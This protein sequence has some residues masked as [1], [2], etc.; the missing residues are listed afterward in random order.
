MRLISTLLGLLFV[1]ALGLAA[2]VLLLPDPTPRVTATVVPSEAERRWGTELLT[3]GLVRGLDAGDSRTIALSEREFAVLTHLV[4]VR[5]IEGLGSKS[6]NEE[7]L[8]S[9]GLGEGY[10]D[11]EASLPLPWERG[12]YLNLDLRLVQAQGPPRIARLQVGGLPL[13]PAVAGRLAERG[14]GALAEADLVQGVELSADQARITYGW[15]PD[16]L[17]AAG[18]GM[19]D[20]ADRHRLLAAQIRLA[21]I[22]AEV[23]GRGAIPLA[24]LL[25][26]LLATAPTGPEQDPAADNRAAI[27]ALAIYVAGEAPPSSSD[28]SRPIP[29][30][31][32]QLR[33][34]ADLA[35]HY[36]ASAV[37]ATE[38]GSALSDLIGFA[39]E[40]RDSDG[41]SGFSFADLAADRAGIRFAELATGAAEDALFV[42]GM[43]RAGLDEGALMPA[44]EGLPEGL[45]QREFQRDFGSHNSDAYRQ[46]V[47]HIDGRIDRLALFTG[48]SPMSSAS[49]R[50]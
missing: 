48:A 5:L 28:G 45:S 43:A 40:L 20:R 26:R 31:S 15:R 44:I 38:G 50:G 46:I 7:V 30:R 3:G 29:V 23:P 21:D 6:P 47:A 34:R 14:L 41:G 24:Q 8:T 2:V 32:V 37:I 39:K 33:G 18:R 4:A 19:L 1:L 35:K 22:L 49:G 17:A 27:L 9:V 42:Q 11:I 10:V 12:G 13:P 36:I 16:A 25:S